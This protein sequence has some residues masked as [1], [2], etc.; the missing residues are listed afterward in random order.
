MPFTFSHPAIILP[1]TRRKSA[2]FSVSGLVAG[3]LVP[4]FE[5]FF[6]L[7]KATSH[8]S[9][10]LPGLVL[11]DW[12]IGLLV[13]WLFH[14]FIK[15]PLADHL[16]A[17]WCQRFQPFLSFRWQSLFTSGL[18]ALSLSILLGA[19]LHLGWDLFVHATADVVTPLFI[20][21]RN[22]P[23]GMA[24]LRLYYVIWLLYSLAGLFFLV[25]VLWHL[26]RNPVSPRPSRPWF[27]VL[28]LGGTG[29]AAFVHIRQN[30]YYS[31][32][33]MA[34]ITIAYFLLVLLLLCVCW[35]VFRK[36]T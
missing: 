31:V 4:D 8:F 28:L 15:S 7:Q 19:L 11:F 3:S 17:A 21:P 2:F 16:P 23:T 10:T 32:D 36:A 18:G 1:F 5:Y 20:A 27:W 24:A 6:S 22:D 13:C 33:D 26:P 30:P 14:F 35:K 34:V 9:H 29:L 12:P 25:V